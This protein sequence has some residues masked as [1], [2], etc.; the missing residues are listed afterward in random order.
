MSRGRRYSLR[1]ENEFKGNI[2][3]LAEAEIIS[4]KIITRCINTSK[5]PREVISLF[6]HP[7]ELSARAGEQLNKL[8][9]G[10]E[11]LLI[12]KA[13]ELAA[14]RKSGILLESDEIVAELTAALNKTSNSAKARVIK[15]DFGTGATA[16]YKGNKVVFHLD[17]TKVS[18]DLIAQF[19]E[20]LE[21]LKPVDH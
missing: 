15:R 7:G 8:F 14:K 3:A 20:M 19:E 13:V 18:H 17:K 21:K 12:E 10:Q 2:S 4:R 5:L 6:S 11:K 9:S 16:H 1:L